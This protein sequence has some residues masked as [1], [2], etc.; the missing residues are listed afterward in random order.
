MSYLCLLFFIL[1]SGTFF[2]TSSNL[3]SSLKRVIS[4]LPTSQ[5]GRMRFHST[6][7]KDLKTPSTKFAEVLFPE[8]S[9]AQRQYV[10]KSQDL[11]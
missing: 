3:L 7:V 4:D 9:Y 2:E 5:L 1:V 11:H 10:K 6:E 8:A